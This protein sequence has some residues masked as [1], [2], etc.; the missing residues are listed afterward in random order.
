MRRKTFDALMTSVGLALTIVLIVAGGLL[1][2]ASTFT[3]DQVHDQL[4]QQQIFFPAHGSPA[5]APSDIGRYLDK[6]A[7]QQLTTGPQAEAYANHFIAVHV[8]EIG[9]G[10]TYAQLSAQAKADPGN[11]KLAAQVSTLFQGETLRGLLLN[12]YAFGTIATIAGI[13]AIVSFAA[14]GVL[15]LLSALGFWHL[16]RTS[17]EAELLPGLSTRSAA[18]PAVV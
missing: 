2:W 7:G 12:A 5:L 3:H 9:G 14:A 11:A 15:L 18:P 17:F 13:A 16:R 6:Y 8:R 10:Q 1:T 4:A